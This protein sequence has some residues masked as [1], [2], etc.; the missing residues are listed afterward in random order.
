MIFPGDWNHVALQTDDEEVNQIFEMIHEW[1][2]EAHKS[3]ID[4]FEI[5]QAM[6]L[7]GVVNVF[8][9]CGPETKEADQFLSELKQIVFML[10]DHYTEQ[11]EQIKH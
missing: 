3:D 5:Y 9:M 1:L 4:M 7:V 8:H 10:L 6:T 2:T 11:E